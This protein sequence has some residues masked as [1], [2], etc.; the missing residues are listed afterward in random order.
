MNEVTRKAALYFSSKP[1]KRLT[2]LVHLPEMSKAL[3][4]ILIFLW[5]WI[6]KR[7]QTT[8]LLWKCRNSFPNFFK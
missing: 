1:E 2:Y 7:E 3:R 4:A 6:T 5:I 8:L